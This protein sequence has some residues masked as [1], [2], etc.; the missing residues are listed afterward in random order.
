MPVTLVYAE[1]VKFIAFT[2][3]AGVRESCGWPGV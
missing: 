2:P 3:E 1:N